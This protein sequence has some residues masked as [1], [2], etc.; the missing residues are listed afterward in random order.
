MCDFERLVSS[1]SLAG[2][3]EEVGPLGAGLFAADPEHGRDPHHQRHQI[4]DQ[5]Q[6]EVRPV[7]LRCLKQ[8]DA[9]R[10]RSQVDLVLSRL[11]KPDF[12]LAAKQTPF[13]AFSADIYEKEVIKPSG[14]GA[15]GRCASAIMWMCY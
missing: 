6:R 9:D 3:V 2:P 4:L 1:L 13:E 14:D 5:E 12:R 11:S 10:R 8:R 15:Q 7:Q